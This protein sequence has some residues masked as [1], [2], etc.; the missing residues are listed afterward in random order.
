[1]TLPCECV[2]TG[3]D[4]TSLAWLGVFCKQRLLVRV[5]GQQA[6]LRGRER[7]AFDR[8]RVLFLRVVLEVVAHEG[9]RAVF[10]D[11]LVRVLHQCRRQLVEERRHV[12]HPFA[13]VPEQADALLKRW[14]PEAPRYAYV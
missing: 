11:V 3:D 5:V 8:L 2:W 1:M 6:V 9:I 13:V 4:C 12:K 10:V 14:L 7:V